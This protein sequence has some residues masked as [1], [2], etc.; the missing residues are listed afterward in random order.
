MTTTSKFQNMP[1]FYQGENAQEKCLNAK[2]E[3]VI[4]TNPRYPSFTQ[5]HFTAGDEEQFNQYRDARNYNLCQ[6]DISLHDNLFKDQIFK[7]WDKYKNIGATAVINT[8]RYLFNKFKKGIFVKIADNKL[9]VFLPF[10]KA[11]YIN[12]WGNQIN[13]DPKFDDLYSF[14]EYIHNL[15]GFPFPFNNRSVNPDVEQWYGN[16]CL[17]RYDMTRVGKYYYPSEGDTN[18]GTIKNMLENL[19][20]ER[21]I[22][23]IEFFINRRDF[24]VLKRDGTEPYDNIWD[25]A[26]KPLL[27]HNYPK[28]V[29][30]LSM[31]TSDQYA[32]IT[33]P[34]Y[35]DWARVQAPLNIFFPKSCVDYDIPFNKN[36]DSKIPTAVFRGGSTGCGVT[37]ETN[38]RL[39]L[40]YIS[41]TT[42]RDNMGIA[43]L[44]AGITKW[45]LRPRKVKGEKY[46][47]TI[48]IGDLPFDK[49]EFLSPVQQSNYKYIVNVDG[50]VSAFRLSLELNMGCVIL[51]VESKWKMWYKDLLIP[52]KHYVPVK[53]D[54]SD[55]ID[56]IKWCRN[57]DKKC[58]EIVKNAEEFFNRYLQRNG[59]LDYMQKTLVDLKDEMG[60][61]LYNNT[62]ILDTQIM[63]ER[64]L[65]KN[66]DYPITDRT[67]KDIFRLPFVARNNSVLQAMT[68][69]LNM[70]E[71]SNY[72]LSEIAVKDKSYLVT[73][74]LSSITK[75]N[76]A[77]FNFVV[78]TTTDEQKLLEQ[79]HDTYVGVKA[80]N[81]LTKLIP[82]FVYT[83][84]EYQGNIV[85]EYIDGE[86]LYDY[87]KSDRFKFDEYILILIQLCLAIEIAQNKCALVHYDLTPWN[88]IL[89]RLDE[90]IKI[91]YKLEKKT[92]RVKTAII[93]VI[94][95]YG[96]S[97][98]IIDQEHHGFINMFQFSPMQDIIT[99]LIKSIE[100][101][102]NV[103]RLGKNEFTNLLYLANFLTGNKY[104]RDRFS[105][106]GGMKQFMKKAGKY[107]CLIS[108]NKYE[109]NDLT[110]M[111]LIRY[112]Y[113]KMSKDYELIANSFGNSTGEI[114]NLMD[115]SNA[116]QIFEYIL[117][118]TTELRLNSYLNVFSRLK[119][120]TLPI[121]DNLL[122][123]YYAAQSL[124]HN[125]LSVR[126]DMLNFLNSEGLSNKYEKIVTSTLKYIKKVYQ[127]VIMDHK[128][129]IVE[130]SVNKNIM[131][132]S[133]TKEIFL[134]PN[135]V[136]KY[137]RKYKEYKIND[138]SE[139]K[140]IIANIL[141]YNGTYKLSEED[142]KYYSNM[143]S[144]LLEQ[145]SIMMILDNANVN[146][147]RTIA[148]NIYQKDLTYLDDKSDCSDLEK[149]KVLY[150]NILTEL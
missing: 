50:H 73:N 66:Y 35:E 4:Q 127:K 2:K 138:L 140:D 95:D 109:L 123:N 36:W 120:C 5:K 18:I 112:I 117:S 81:E 13:I 58:Q 94:I 78:K 103:R 1:D 60:V 41:A 150:R 131:V 40:A 143:F 76:L 146:T 25:S 82:N 31:A 149:Y 45:N 75:W 8:F 61:Y 148:S 114:I 104:R 88:I 21:Q 20:E 51:M 126:E 83:F 6:D 136:L 115:K 97:S 49:V 116:R 110:P 99:I 85:V 125:L 84:G 147:L 124:E 113:K 65:V 47:K 9:V 52:Y 22:P 74:K 144:K 121:S 19:C 11:C 130:Y 128:K 54:L 27:S 70:I 107:A 33:M 48:E 96:K 68:W 23:D 16:N 71:K 100:Q 63:K 102:L 26:N 108:D 24:P 57:N 122:L 106:A 90:P 91:D 38:P 10:S 77:G 145:K 111:D 141:S 101:I 7:E 55:I 28:Y 43:Y 37:I 46:L 134:D 39:K 98:V 56:Q 44:D 137:I 86:T 135:S 34:T 42:P 62:N 119:H 3:D 80:I 142:K 32:D 69:I 29:P 17:I 105:S 79:Y 92:Y 89:Q 132:D 67:V 72:D 133:Y 87:I 15:Q 64:D 30:I 93:P 12:E 129:K 139:Y 118:D 53:S 14:L 59:I